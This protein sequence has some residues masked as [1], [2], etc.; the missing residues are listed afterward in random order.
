MNKV[1]GIVGLGYVGLPL[2]IEFAKKYKVVGFDIN[3]S[4]ISELENGYDSTL[5]IDNETL[6][7]VKDNLV[8]SSKSDKIKN[9]NVYIIT[10][11]TPIDKANNPISNL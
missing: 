1:I 10:V 4:R 9:C 3:K 7:S 11:P 5:E 8:F 6:L 2:A